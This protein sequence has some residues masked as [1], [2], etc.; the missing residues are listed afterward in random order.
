MRRHITINTIFFTVL[1]WSTVLYALPDRY[2]GDTS[3]YGGTATASSPNVLIIVDTSG[4]MDWTVKGSVEP[5]NPATTYP[6]LNVCKI[7]IEDGGG[8]GKGKGGGKPKYEYTTCSSN[9]VYYDSDDTKLL[10]N[11]ESVVTSCG[12]ANPKDLLKTTGMYSGKALYATGSCDTS[13]TNTYNLGNYLNWLEGP[14]KA[15]DR[16]KI[17]I[18]RDVVKSIIQTTTG[19][20]FG[21]MKYRSDN[22]GGQFLKVSVSSKDYITTIKNMDEDFNTTTKNRTALLAAVDT[23]PA[24]GATPLAETLYEALRYFNGEGSAFGNTIE[25]GRASCRERV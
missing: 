20:N 11:V 12:T 18:A 3:I 8:G 24:D 1:L 10:D 4:S 16:K 2:T 22:E 15:V 17:D 19:V 21:L 5:Y 9:A 23:L 14:G 13:G 7:K 25:I 6:L